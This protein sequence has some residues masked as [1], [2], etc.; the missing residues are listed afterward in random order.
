MAKIDFPKLLK[1]LLEESDI[2]G[3][4]RS[5]ADRAGEILADN[6]LPFF[7]DYTD[8]GTD[9][10]NAVLKS[11]VELIPKHVWE[12]SKKDS[13]PRLLCDADA[14]VI[15]GATL[16]HDIAM[17]LR[18]DGF[19]ELVRRESRFLPL[20]WFK[21]SHE[22][23]SADGPWHDLWEDFQREARR[24]S[25]SQL[26]NII[27]EESARA[28][29]FHDL[30][31]D[32]GQWE[33]NHCLIVGEFIRRHHAR[34]A[35]EIAIYGFPGLPVG[36]G[37][38]QFPAMG[39][40]EGH[41]LMRLADLI[42]LTARSHGTSLRVC[43]AYLEASPLYPG[44]PRPLGTAV[45]YPMALL[46]VADYL[47]I[48]RQRAPAVL[49]QLRNP[50]SPISVQEW[51]K[52]RA[53]QQIGPAN[54]PR[55]KMVTVTTELSLSLF[56]Q[57]KDLLAGMQAEMD[58]STA[59][60]DEAYG[61]MTELG[62]NQL[63]LATRRVYSNLESPAFR[64]N[65]PYI[66]NR[67]GFTADPNLLT[68]LVEPLYG[69]QPSVGVRELMQNAVDAV[70][71]LEAWSEAHNISIQSLYLPEQDCDVLIEYIK[72]ENG[73]WFLHVR[74]RGIGMRSDTIQ[75]Y[76]LRA[77]ASF[78]RSA[79]WAKEFL[80][81]KGRPRV[82]RAGRFGI[83]AFA[84]FLLGPSFKLW[85]RHAGVDKSMG[86]SIEA[87][88][89]SP[90]IEIR[91][92]EG[93]PVGTTIEVTLSSETVEALKLEEAS[94][95]K[96]N[97]LWDNVDWFCWDWPKVTQR[98]I[99]GPE[100]KLLE[101]R[102][103]CPVRKSIS[104]PD[105]S[106]IHPQGFDAVFWTFGKQPILTCNGI[107]VSEPR[108]YGMSDAVYS[109]PKDAQLTPPCIAVVDGA[110]NL[111]LTTQ[112]YQ[113]SQE[114]VPFVDELVRDVSLSFIAHALVCGPKSP[115]EA[116]SSRG[117]YPLKFKQ[118]T[119]YENVNEIE[120]PF[121]KGL[122][123]WCVTSEAMVP[124]DP[125]LYT[126]LKSNSCLVYGV[127]S[128]DKPLLHEHPPEE[129]LL[130]QARSGGFAILPWFGCLQVPGI[131]WNERAEQATYQLRPILGM[132]A[133]EGVQCLGSADAARVLVSALPQ[134]QFGAEMRT[135][136]TSFHIEQDD[137][138]S[139]QPIWSKVESCNFSKEWF[140]AQNE[141]STA[142][143]PLKTI[144]K[145]WETDID[146]DLEY[147]DHFRDSYYERKKYGVLFVAE[148]RIRPTNSP[149]SIIAKIWNECLGAKGIPFDTSSREALIAEGYEHAELKRHLDAWQEMKRSGSTWATGG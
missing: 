65:L 46:R 18:P 8:H 119:E 6:K 129:D 74:D 61:T 112:R 68:L 62:L 126:L 19:L 134:Y 149:K 102:F 142:D 94:Y 124:A 105:W 60:L 48:D 57:L 139:K 99:R 11:E 147:Y 43:K 54:N 81:E 78:R 84:V 120:A 15:I 69:K 79:E 39:K 93:L 20:S 114:T 71:E 10:I 130:E 117:E 106:V 95:S 123:R 108:R 72:R 116:L 41:P 34:L 45:L 29:K 17:H 111:P 55:G 82:L 109:W 101:R 148:V 37:E 33:R 27:G 85:T 73:T 12:H 28:W 40:E 64:D 38:G 7:P 42:G 128:L 96:F 2:Q 50:Q 144:L 56:L 141:E 132:I 4:I 107:R 36:S 98:V 97:G 118:F 25:D 140:E 47:Q 49:L 53:V 100:P 66:P 80:D 127:L 135:L 16:L 32:T 88:D 145:S 110:A 91:R 103:A 75:N 1:A 35:H 121:A 92:V 87:S 137:K 143:V 67:T 3:P 31:N 104:S 21:E 90:L 122:L 146:L 136:H 24:F 70:C 52:H 89:S 5:L 44:T 22:G 9:H 133:R 59:V 63:N 13:E 83:G 77:G 125:W 23:H 26:S 14:A 131:D 138:N 113:L 51:K 115:E 76:F 58:H 86:Y 30:P